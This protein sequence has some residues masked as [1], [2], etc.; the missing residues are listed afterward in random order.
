[1]KVHN[2]EI[3]GNSLDLGHLFSRSLLQ[4]LFDSSN[5]RPGVLAAQYRNEFVSIFKHL[6][7]H[8]HRLMCFVILFMQRLLLF[9]M[10]F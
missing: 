6:A 8:H 3:S 9:K 1:M 10:L 5:L 7:P 4:N 2:A